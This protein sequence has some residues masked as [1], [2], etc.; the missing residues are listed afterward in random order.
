MI[1][2]TCQAL[3][4]RDICTGHC[5][6]AFNYLKRLLTDPQALG[7]TPF[8]TALIPCRYLV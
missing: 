2:V 7:C 4:L 3:R 1:E 8:Q 5:I 6:M